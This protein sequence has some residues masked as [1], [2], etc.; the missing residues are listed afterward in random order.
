MRNRSLAIIGFA[1]LLLLLALAR[2]AVAQEQED[3]YLGVSFRNVNAEEAKALGWSARRGVKVITIINPIPAEKGNLK[4]GDIILTAEGIEAA[5]FYHMDRADGGRTYQP[6]L[7]VLLHLKRPG[8][9]V[10]LVV[11]RDGQERKIAATLV[12]R[13]PA[14]PPPA[15]A[16]PHNSG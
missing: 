8:E 16:Y 3:A 14:P 12:A 9:K 5:G 7:D 2:L 10:E 4:V 1:T 13:I 6:R 15:H 11:F